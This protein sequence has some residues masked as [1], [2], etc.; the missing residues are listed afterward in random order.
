M[1]TELHAAISTARPSGWQV[2][3]FSGSVFA[4][5]PAYLPYHH[6]GDIVEAATSGGGAGRPV[7]KLAAVPVGAPPARS[8]RCLVVIS[9]RAQVT[10]SLARVLGLANQGD[11]SC[12]AAFQAIVQSHVAVARELLADSPQ[13][14]GETVRE[15]EKDA[16]AAAAI[17]E[18]VRVTKVLTAGEWRFKHHAC[19]E[20]F[21]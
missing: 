18:A 13:A 4:E 8:G 6:L 3:K 19:D 5:T 2:H 20:P 15:L 16:E 10:D 21:H 7:S 1:A 14:F 12:L 17:L 11:A 9:A